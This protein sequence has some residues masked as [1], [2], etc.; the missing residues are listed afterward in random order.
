MRARGPDTNLEQVKH[1]DSHYREPP[2]EHTPGAKAPG[3]GAATLKSQSAW[4][5]ASSGFCSQARR[6]TPTHSC[7]STSQ[8]AN[9]KFWPF[10]TVQMGKKCGCRAEKICKRRYRH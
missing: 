2:D 4:I 10:F 9:S 7:P 3:D 8:S 6:L 5:A 1:T